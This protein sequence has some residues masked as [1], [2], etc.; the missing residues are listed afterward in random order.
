MY[1]AEARKRHNELK[2]RLGKCDI[3]IKRGAVT[4]SEPCTGVDEEAFVLFVIAGAVE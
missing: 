2:A 1:D 3:H 4:E